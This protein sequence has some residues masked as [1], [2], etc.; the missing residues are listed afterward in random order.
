MIRKCSALAVAMTLAF[1]V[2]AAA[3]STDNMTV[4]DKMAKIETMLYGNEQTGALV[5]RAAQVEQDVYGVAS[6]ESVMA[7]ANRLY[8]TMIVSDDE[9]ASFMAKLNAT[10][11][12]IKH[13][14]ETGSVK[15][16]IEDMET[17]VNGA[18]S[19]GN[20]SARLDR[21]M[22]LAYSTDEF[23]TQSVVVPADTLVQIALMT[24]IDTATDR[25]GDIIKFQVAEDVLVDN[26][27]VFP[28][29]AIGEGV[30]TK[31]TPAKSFG[32]NAKL[33]IDFHS[34]VAFDGTT[35]DTILGEKAK[36]QT[37]T[38]AAAAGA[39]VVGL[40]VLGPVGLVGGIFVKGEEL[41]VPE[42]ALIYI[43]TEDETEVCG[44]VQ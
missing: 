3:Q 18:P 43:Q 39:S 25:V 37:K 1:S 22:K 8:E 24:P 29:G 11:W 5:D 9:E 27:L 13:E 36:E 6:N 26:V 14:I 19:T 28:K 35:Q 40:A 31:V 33:E 38:L 23:A 7:K 2:T 12:E 42:G 17:I 4:L 30:I 21:M 16:R 10:E 15:S 32:R 20:Y 41:Q 44:L 34:L